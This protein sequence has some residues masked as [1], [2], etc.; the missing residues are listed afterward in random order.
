MKKEFTQT[1][2]TT[3]QL[4]HK[5]FQVVLRQSCIVAARIMA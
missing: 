3:L 2:H 4:S 1:L 5:V